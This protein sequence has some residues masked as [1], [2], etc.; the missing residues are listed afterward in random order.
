M[1]D[2]RGLAAFL[3]RRMATG[4][5]ADDYTKPVGPAA[6][7]SGS[8]KGSGLEAPGNF[9]AASAGAFKGGLQ[10][11]APNATQAVQ[12]RSVADARTNS[13]SAFLGGDIAQREAP[14]PGTGTPVA[15][16]AAPVTPAS[17]A[18]AVSPAVGGAGGPGGPGTVQPV[19]EKSSFVENFK[20]PMLTEADYDAMQDTVK[21]FLPDGRGVGYGGKLTADINN[22]YRKEL[23]RDIGQKDD[24]S[25][26][27]A[28]L[29][30]GNVSLSDLAGDLN[31]TEE[32]QEFNL[33]NDPLSDAGFARRLYRDFL[34][35]EPDSEG[36][37]SMLSQG[38]DRQAAIDF[39][40]NSQEFQ[41]RGVPKEEAD[42]LSQRLLVQGDAFVG[43]VPEGDDA[44]LIRNH[45]QATMGRGPTEREL[46]RL[47]DLVSRGVLT[48][49]PGERNLVAALQARKAAG[50]ARG[51]RI[52]VR[53]S[54]GGPL[55]EPEGMCKGGRVKGYA[56][57]GRVTN[58][59]RFI[60]EQVNG[61][62]VTVAEKEVVVEKK[63]ELGAAEKALLEK[64][65]RKSL[66]EKVKA[67]LSAL[68]D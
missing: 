62:P 52:K 5:R 15:K 30:A 53:R 64:Y 1:N 50:W 47:H 21:Y 28:R 16:P 66:A 3:P 13:L 42:R 65:R 38:Y 58:R 7:F 56:E 55:D 24:V 61:K 59:D 22:L 29:A 17:A 19:A 41:A 40:R 68:L 8:P 25:L 39:I 33:M 12:P 4:G 49:D 63:P 34:G 60:E 27:R 31:S 67:G 46:A 32:G 45:F 20:T 37:A 54:V 14:D 43:K 2:F 48:R 26:A 36:L 11:P 9:T 57:G 44:S 18:P 51:G 23:G 35:R 6:T 10:T